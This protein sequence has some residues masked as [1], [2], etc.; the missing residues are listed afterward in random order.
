VAD[1]IDGIARHLAG[2]GLVTYDPT[3]VTGDCFAEVQPAQPD[4]IVT[5]TLYG[6]APIDSLLPYDTPSLQVRTRGDADPR[7][8]RTRAQGIYEALN[9]LGPITLADGS[10]LLLAVANQTPA[11]MGQDTTG[12]CEHVVNFSLEV[13]APSAHRPA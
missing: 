11:F 8:S 10:Y 12:R 2:L 1:L 6:G 4:S 9:G 7:T 3:G 13:H 5:L